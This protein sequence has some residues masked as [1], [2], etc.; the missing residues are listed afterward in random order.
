[1]GGWTGGV[2]GVVSA[3][4]TWLQEGE[5]AVRKLTEKRRRCRC[6]DRPNLANQLNL[7]R[8]RKHRSGGT[9]DHTQ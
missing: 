1:M 8:E 5:G 6:Q 2:V 3:G 9:K 4:L 7:V